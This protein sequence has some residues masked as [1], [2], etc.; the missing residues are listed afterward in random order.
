MPL[1][2]SEGSR[3]SAACVPVASKYSSKS[4]A[5]VTSRLVD[6][7]RIRGSSAQAMPSDV[8]PELSQ[9][10]LPSRGSGVAPLRPHL[11]KTN[12]LQEQEAATFRTANYLMGA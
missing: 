9:P 2:H 8:E 10:E 1:C 11:R 7:Q 5:P 4:G 3:I 6:A 12:L